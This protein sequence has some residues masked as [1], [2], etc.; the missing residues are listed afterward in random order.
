MSA[1]HEVMFPSTPC[2]HEP[3]NQG[4]RTQLSG[5]EFPGLQLHRFDF[6][7]RRQQLCCAS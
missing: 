5:P 6:P 2:V 7:P 1:A 4:G 3:V